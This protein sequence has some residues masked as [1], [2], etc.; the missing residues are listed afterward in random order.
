M[1]TTIKGENR[2]G[3]V[4]AGPKVNPLGASARLEHRDPHHPSATF[5][6]VR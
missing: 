1:K 6:A 4:S 2:G 3:E 5:D